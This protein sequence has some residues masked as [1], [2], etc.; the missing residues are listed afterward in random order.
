MIN[1]ILRLHYNCVLLFILFIL[2]QIVSLILKTSP[3]NPNILMYD[4]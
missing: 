2:I 3:I 1:Q 4:V